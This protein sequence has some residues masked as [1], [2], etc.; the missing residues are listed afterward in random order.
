MRFKRANSNS[1]KKVSIAKPNTN[2]VKLQKQ[3]NKITK[4]LTSTYENHYMYGNFSNAVVTGDYAYQNLCNYATLAPCFGTVGNDYN[5]V[6]K[7][8]AKELQMDIVLTNGNEMDLMFCTYYIVT[9]KN[10]ATSLYDKNTGAITL[11]KPANY[12]TNGIAGYS[13]A[14]LNPKDF[15]IHYSKQVT[16]GNNSVA[17]MGATGAGNDDLK[18]IYRKHL[19]FKVNQVGRNPDG[20]MVGL[21]CNQEASKQWYILF[22]NDNSGV[23]LTYPVMDIN[24]VWKIEVAV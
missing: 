16:L 12:V 2:V 8:K 11:S 7:F 9:L 18:G 19:S 3:V 20:N 14:L 6:N 10:E 5:F 21:A 17:A 13:Q 24:I 15:T 1:K 23:D 4:S 22:F